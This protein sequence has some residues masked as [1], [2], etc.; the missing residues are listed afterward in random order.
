MIFTFFSK[1][2]GGNDEHRFLCYYSFLWFSSLKR[3]EYILNMPRRIITV[4]VLISV[5]HLLLYNFRLET[6]ANS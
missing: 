4:L 3:E 6:F 5:Y 2:K 1:D